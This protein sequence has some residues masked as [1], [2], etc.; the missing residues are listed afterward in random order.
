[1]AVPFERLWLVRLT[2]M[3]WCMTLCVM[4]SSS[5]RSRSMHIYKPGCRLSSAQN[6]L[7]AS[8][9][10]VMATLYLTTGQ[11]FTESSQSGGGVITT[12]VL[13]DNATLSCTTEGFPVCPNNTAADGATA[14]CPCINRRSV[15]IGGVTGDF[16]DPVFAAMEQAG[17]DFN[18]TL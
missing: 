15:V 3:S 17:E 7:Q 5:F 10:V 8:M 13:P 16:W 4:V 6:Y 2:P 14:V 12:E 9:P 18:I 11:R 1:M